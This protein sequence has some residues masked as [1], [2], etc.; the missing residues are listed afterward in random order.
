MQLSLREEA[1]LAVLLAAA[2]MNFSLRPVF[3]MKPYRPAALPSG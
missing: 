1:A 2:A 3:C